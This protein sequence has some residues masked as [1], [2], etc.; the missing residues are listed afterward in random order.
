MQRQADE[1]KGTRITTLSY[2]ND[3]GR[4]T[5]VRH[6][7]SGPWETLPARPCLRMVCTRLRSVSPEGYVQ[8]LKWVGMLR[9]LKTRPSV[10]VGLADLD[11]SARSSLPA[12]ARSR[13][14]KFVTARPRAKL[15]TFDLGGRRGLGHRKSRWHGLGRRGKFG[16]VGHPASTNRANSHKES[17]Y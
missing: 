1:D 3:Y 6:G 10:V 12:E 17:P 8:S 4:D 15:R 2:P 11:A 14:S 7:L 5:H 13:P 16:V 9:C